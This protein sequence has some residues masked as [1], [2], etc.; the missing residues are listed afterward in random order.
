MALRA[1]TG[2]ENVGRQSVRWQSPAGGCE[3]EPNW[4]A[5]PARESDPRCPDGPRHGRPARVSTQDSTCT[6]PGAGPTVWPGWVEVRAMDVVYTHCCGLEVHQKEVVAGLLG[7]GPDGRATKTIR[8]YGTM[9]DDLEGLAAWL[10]GAGCTQVALESTGVSWQPVWNVLEE[11]GTFELLLVKARHVRNVPGRKTDVND[12]EW[13]ADLVRHGLVRG[14]Y[15]P[16]RAQ[17]ELRESTRY[18]TE[19]LEERTAHVNRLQKTLETANS[20]L[21]AVATDVLGVSGRAILAAL[22]DPDQAATAAEL[23]ELARGRLRTKIPELQRALIGRLRPHHRFMLAELLVMIDAL[24]ERI[25]ALSAEI[26]ER[27]RPFADDLARLDTIPGIG[28]RVA[29]IV[30]AELDPDLVHFHA[31]AR[32]RLMGWVVSWQPRECREAQDR[33]DPLGQRCPPP[34]P[35]RSRPRRP[36]RPDLSPRPVLPPQTPTRY[37]AGRRRRRSLHHPPHLLRPHPQARLRRPRARL[38]RPP[39]RRRHRA[40]TRP[41]P[42]TA[43]QQGH[44]R[45]GRLTM[46]GLLFSGQ[47]QGLNGVLSR[48]R[49]PAGPSWRF[50][51]P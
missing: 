11:A 7:P 38:L 35:R 19:L 48:R 27:T 10:R 46:P 50:G 8:R 43:R 5:E 39:R 12:A 34:R 18:R 51:A 6:E 13:L 26:A 45:E 15:V 33:Q 49:L 36:P 4:R 21:G 29:E 1:T 30:V 17:R 31:P 9:T 40:P 14:S 23:A 47:W 22:V 44:H 3:V 20:K 25:D 2:D 32:A 28:Q 42:R 37:P 16:D 24:D 41:S